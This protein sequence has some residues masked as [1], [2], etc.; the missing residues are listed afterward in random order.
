MQK[1]DLRLEQEKSRQMNYLLKEK[2]RPPSQ[3]LHLTEP[4]RAMLDLGAL[5]LF[6]PWLNSLTGGDGHR[7]VARGAPFRATEIVGAVGGFAPPRGGDLAPRPDARELRNPARS[8][9]RCG[10]LFTATS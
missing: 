6:E 2:F 9:R 10:E 5:Q 8:V 7:A 3:T 4:L 1:R